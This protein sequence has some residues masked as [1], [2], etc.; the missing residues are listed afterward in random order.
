MLNF[1]G[2]KEKGVKTVFLI[3]ASM[4]IL[5]VAMIFLFL[6]KEGLSIFKEVPLSSVW[7]DKWYPVSFRKPQFG[8]I[9]LLAGSL[10]VTAIAIIFAVPLAVGTAI[11]IAEIAKPMEREFL[12]PFIEVL[13]GIPSVVNGF[14]GMV[15]LSPL[16]KKV[17]SLSTGLNALTG[18]LMLGIM[19]VPTI[20]SISEDAI[21]NVPQSYKQA[22]LA[23]GASFLQTTF[24]VTVPAAL[25]GIIASVMLGI[26]R[27]IG[28]T[29][30]VMMVTGNAAIIPHSAFDSVRT[31][32]ATIAA[33][34]GEVPFG[35]TH[36]HAL[37][38]VG[39]ILL[40]ITFLINYIAQKVLHKYRLGE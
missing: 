2:C 7:V 36:Y 10:L 24:K 9:P 3:T 27:V 21:R 12:K 32:T 4:S 5:V 15:I 37:F 11:Y 13:A 1:R 23:L 35:S 14:L 16:V 18:G 8:I 30:T 29:M 25:S 19:A 17:F 38:L 26:G 33:E 20:I 6:G 28:E 22:S 39:F 31:M 40:S 34:M